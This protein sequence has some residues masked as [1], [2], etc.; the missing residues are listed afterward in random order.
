[1]ASKEK[2]GFQREPKM[3]LNKEV[4]KRW[5]KAFDHHHIKA[6]FRTKPMGVRDTD[7]F[8]KRCVD[9]KFVVQGTIIPFQGL[10]FDYNPFPRE[11]IVCEV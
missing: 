9:P 7:G 8:A 2:D 6:S 4:V 5:A 10:E 11:N 3:T 1:M